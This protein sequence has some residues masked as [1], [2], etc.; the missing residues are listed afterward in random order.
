[1]ESD[2]CALPETTAQDVR[3]FQKEYLE[4]SKAGDRGAPHACFRSGIVPSA[5]LHLR[6]RALFICNICFAC[7]FVWALVHSPDPAHVE[8]GLDLAQGMINA[9]EIDQQHLND[10][11]YM[12]A[13]VS[14]SL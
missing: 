2:S 1:M 4:L 10:L 6:L 11:V 14:L 13:V 12:C 9:R 7:S 8:R 5:W 3:K